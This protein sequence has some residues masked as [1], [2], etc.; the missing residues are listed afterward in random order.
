M[1]RALNPIGAEP[2]DVSTVVNKIIDGIDVIKI[3]E[4]A[5]NS[6]NKK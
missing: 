2:R 5:S 1:F 3:L 6:L 4:M